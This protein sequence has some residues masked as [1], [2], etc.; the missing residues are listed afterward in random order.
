MVIPTTT[1]LVQTLLHDAF[2]ATPRTAQGIQDGIGGAGWMMDL[3][4][5]KTVA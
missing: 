3:H 1:G 5:L 2:G 4:Q